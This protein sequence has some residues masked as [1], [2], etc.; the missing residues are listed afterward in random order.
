MI[1]RLLR[2]LG[3]PLDWI[4]SHDARRIVT[5]IGSEVGLFFVENASQ[6]TDDQD[7]NVIPAQDLVS[8]Y[9]VNSVFGTGGAYPNGQIVVLVVFC[10]DGVARATA[11]LFLPL[12]DLFRGKTALKEMIHPP[13]DS[14]LWLGLKRRFSDRP[15]ILERTNCVSRIKDIVDYECYRRTIDGCRAAAKELK[16]E[17]IEV[18]QLWAGTEF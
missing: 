16:C 11:E 15:D 5:T 9:G 3:V 4:D 17:L 6:A 12:A 10:R 7:R 18:E 2:E 1:A 8:A 14:G 13:I